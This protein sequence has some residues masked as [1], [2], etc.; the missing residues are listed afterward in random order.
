MLQ[1][2]HRAGATVALKD[3]TADEVDG[4]RGGEIYRAAFNIKVLRCSN[5][6]LSITLPSKKVLDIMHDYCIDHVFY[7]YHLALVRASSIGN[8]RKLDVCRGDSSG[9]SGDSE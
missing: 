7:S 2:D 9:T 1:R 4:E 6:L 3:F 8:N 5:V